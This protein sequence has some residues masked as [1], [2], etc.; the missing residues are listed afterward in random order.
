ME[1]LHNPEIR[2]KPVAVGGNEKSR[3]GII[4]TA[5]EIAKSYGV[6][7]A[8]PLWSARR[9]CPELI[10]VPPNYSLYSRFSEMMRK[11]CCDYTD[12]LEPFGL[13]ECWLDVT[14]SGQFGSGAEIS[15][16]IRSRVKSE[17]G[18]TVSVGVSFNKI[19]AKLGSDYK[20]P[21][22]V[23]VISRDNFREIVWGL[24]ACNL[25]GVG[26]S[27]YQKLTSR[28]IKTIGDLATIDIKHL[29][30]ILKSEKTAATLISFA[31]G[32][33]GQPVSNICDSHTVKSVSNSVTTPRDLT[34]LHDAKLV[35]MVLTESVARRLRDD[36]LAGCTVTLI[37]RDNQLQSFTRQH[38]LD[39]HTSSEDDIFNAAFELLRAGYDFHNGLRSIGVSVSE[40]EPCDGGYQFCLFRDESGR[41]KT[42]ALESTMDSLKK[43]FGNGCIGR[44]ALLEDPSL[45]RFD[46]YK[47]HV[48]HPVGYFNSK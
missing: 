2:D 31:N 3:H 19:F 16:K 33:D 30:A 15:E 23:T 25:L 21:D 48:I 13:D 6:V 14:G 9:K 28:G 32:K 10:V 43:R 17:L 38:K 35:L 39:Y 22:A 27:T 1:C 41:R 24:P 26:R 7:T 47:D 20:K 45:T 34:C 18:I 44:A 4:L 42:E 46:P 29:K 5:N 37:A 36:K 12:M 11:I 40:L 8:E